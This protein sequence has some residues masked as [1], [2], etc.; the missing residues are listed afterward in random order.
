MQIEKSVLLRKTTQLH[1]YTYTV[2]TVRGSKVYIALNDTAVMECKQVHLLK[3]YNYSEYNFKILLLYTSTSFQK[4]LK[5]NSVLFS[6]LLH[7]SSEAKLQS[8][9]KCTSITK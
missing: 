9:F 4:V 5:V 1:T 3:Y 2:L 8:C 6:Q 7:A